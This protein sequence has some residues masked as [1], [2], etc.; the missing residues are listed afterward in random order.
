MT[1][2]FFGTEELHPLECLAAHNCGR[3]AGHL[4]S[5]MAVVGTLDSGF[6]SPDDSSQMTNLL[7]S[8]RDHNLKKDYSR[9]FLL[10]CRGLKTMAGLADCRGFR[11][12][13][14]FPPW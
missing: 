5:S 12:N 2:G 3:L 4:L 1:G 10:S 11:I 14:Y 6:K 7:S 8:G 13:G 9:K